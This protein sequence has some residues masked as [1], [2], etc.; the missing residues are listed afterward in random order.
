M[1]TN[2]IIGLVIS[3]FLINLTYAQTGRNIKSKNKNEIVTVKGSV[4]SINHP[5][6]IVKGDDGKNYELR[7]GPSW[8]WKQNKIELKEKGNIEIK[9]ELEKTD[10]KNYIYPYTLIQDGK[11]ITLAD[12]DGNPVWAGGM[13][14]GKAIDNMKG[15][16]NGNGNGKGNCGGNNC[17]NKG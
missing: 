4:T 10:G 11:T 7:L 13:H 12:K 5:V 17:N 1:R 6:A 14:K 16:G 15:K 2:I 8:Y 3:L 9:G